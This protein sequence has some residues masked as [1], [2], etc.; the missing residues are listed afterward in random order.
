MKLLLSILMLLTLQAAGQNSL[1]EQP[2]KAG[3]QLPG[4]KLKKLQ[5]YN[6]HTAMLSSFYED[7]PLIIA[8]W[9]TTCNTCLKS[10]PLLDSLQKKLNNG[11]NILSVT[12][13]GL[14]D[15]KTLFEN[16]AVLKKI[17]QPYIAG[18]KVIKGRFP[19]RYV[20]HIVW[21][22]R[23]GTVVAITAEEEVTESNLLGLIKY[24]SISLFEKNDDMLFDAARPYTTADSL[25]LYKSSLIQYNPAVR[26]SEQANNRLDSNGNIDSVKRVLLLNTTATNLFYNA[27]AHSKGSGNYS[28]P[29]YYRI[30]FN[31]K[32]SSL[33]YYP[34]VSKRPKNK[35]WQTRALYGYELITPML[36]REDF[37]T[38][39]FDELNRYFPIKGSIQKK[40][41][42]CYVLTKEGT[43]SISIQ[44]AGG[45]KK[46]SNDY[47]S[48][49][50]ITIL[51]ISNLPLTRL[52][53]FLNRFSLN[54]PVFCA[55]GL[56][57]PAD[58]VVSMKDSG[59][60]MEYDVQALKKE[61]HKY[62]LTL[63]DSTME[64]DV[65]VLSDK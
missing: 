8:F 55:E 16:N 33:Y 35:N 3:E 28:M 63:K 41:M 48:S 53:G 17:H 22:N 34:D 44:T 14:A 40:Q 13:D 18:D 25:I 56:D 32:D 27:F 60:L 19:H 31:V 47:D 23:S 12:E 57:E 50:D 1:A 7:K 15:V 49:R 65:L 45:Q 38:I 20:P 30:I 59:W 46:F 10:L 29:L 11:F 51:T 54:R 24:G 42:P 6:R 2:I 21:V 52:T 39:M 43:E 9:G 62:G 58:M 37:Y 36:K 61:L 4:L 64:M 5:G 26:A